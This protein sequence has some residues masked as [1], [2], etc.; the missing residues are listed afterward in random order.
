[1]RRILIAVA[2]AIGVTAVH[3]QFVN[4]LF[5][6]DTI[7]GTTINLTVD[8][9]MV[10][11][12]PGDST[13]TYGIN[14]DYLAPTIIWNAGDYMQMNVT[15]LLADTTTMHWHGAHVAPEDDGGPHTKILPGETW[16][17]DFEVLDE[18][19]TMWYHPHLHSKT[20]EQVY[21][22]AAGMLIIRDA[23]EAALDLPRTYGVDD[24]PIII[25]DKSFDANNQFIFSALSDTMLINGTLAPY[26]EVPAQ[27][28]RLRFLNASNQRVYSLD[29]PPNFNP[30]LIATDGGLLEEPH[31]IGN[32]VMSPGERAEVVFDFSNNQ[33][34]NQNFSCNNTLLPFGCSGGPGGPQGPP[35][36]NLDNN[37]FDF[38]EFRVIAP[39]ANPAGTIPTTLNTH[40]IWDENDAVETRVKTFDTLTTGFPYYINGTPFNHHIVN[41]TIQLGN[42][43]VW[44]LVNETDVA[45]PFHIHDVQF[46]VLD[47]NGNPPPPHLAG[48]KDVILVN[49][50]EH[51]RFITKF[52]DHVDDTI[53]YMYHCHNLF[54]EDA[55]MMGQFLVID[56]TG[57]G[58]DEQFLAQ[59]VN[60]HAFPNPTRNTVTIAREA[61]VP[62][63]DVTIRVFDTMGKL[64]ATHRMSEHDQSF[65]VPMNDLESGLYLMDIRNDYGLTEVLRVVKQ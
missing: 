48:R 5:I 57:V 56:T 37:D 61:D 7:S 24:F 65:K 16:S 18:A 50:D 54:H 11:F 26:L 35:G 42:I 15:N 41:D 3:A 55:G 58:L 46:Y 36:N 60:Y 51:I 17:P 34:L 64:H 1:M 33:G 2:M 62:S 14:A 52:E 40:N 12:L 10:S 53:P 19:S 63:W 49:L 20:A 6:P 8:E 38:M 59:G 28:V 25:Q 43:E 29:F 30:T 13:I 32:L 4:P 31:P 39:T 45:H 44:E 21:K 22:G 9:S 47:I 23:N 27:R